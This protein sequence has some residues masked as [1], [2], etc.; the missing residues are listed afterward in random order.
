MKDDRIQ[1]MT[2]DDGVKEIERTPTSASS[3][4]AEAKKRSRSDGGNCLRSYKVCFGRHHRS[5]QHGDHEEEVI[6]KGR[7]LQIG[8]LKERSVISDH[9]DS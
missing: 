2:I 6:R 3:N 9:G 5:S 1:Q 8:S 7:N 4:S